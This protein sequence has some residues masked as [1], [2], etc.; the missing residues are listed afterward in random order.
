M[1]I[2]LN[3]NKTNNLSTYVKTLVA[4]TP[5]YTF[6]DIIINIVTVAKAT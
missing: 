6:L 3:I 1:L 2:L 5:C 4:H